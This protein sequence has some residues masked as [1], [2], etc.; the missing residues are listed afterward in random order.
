MLAST[1]QPILR[2]GHNVWRIERARRAAVLI[3]AAAFFSAVREAMLKARRCIF[4]LG[5]DMHSQTPLVGE[6]GEADDGFPQLFGDFLRELVERRPELDIHLLSWDFAFLYAAERELFPRMRFGWQMPER[7]HFRLDNA[8][9][10]GSSQH[11]KLIIVDDL[12]AFSG[13]LDVTIRRW[14]TSE[15]K[16]DNPHRVDPAGAPY[17]PFHDVQMMVDGEAAK[18]LGDLA[19]RRWHR[20]CGETVDAYSLTEEEHPWPAS[21]E[22]DFTDVD[23]GIARTLPAY[24]ND[25]AVSEVEPLFLDSVEAAERS[26]YIENQFLTFKPF[27]QRLARRLRKNP[28]LEALIIAPEKAESWIE[29]RTM[30][31]GRILFRKAL[32]AAQ[33]RVRLMYPEVESGSG[34][35]STMVHSKVMIID[36]RLLRVGSANLNNRSMAAD[37]ECDLVIEAQTEEHRAAI[38]AVRN[39]LLADHCGVTPAAVAEEL[40]RDPSVLSA[41]TRLSG[42]GHRLKPID[43][44]DPDDEELAAQLRRIADPYDPIGFET[45]NGLFES[46]L[47]ARQRSALLKLSIAVALFLALTLVWYVTPLSEYAD[48]DATRKTFAAFAESWYAAPAVVGIFVAAGLLSF[49]VTVL[50]AATAAGFGPALGLLY[51]S[52]GAL[53]SAFVTYAIGSFVGRG[54]LRQV[55][56]PRLDKVRKRI[57][58]RGVIAVAAIRLVPIAPFTLVNL[59]AGASEIRAV[60]FMLGTILGLA[61]GMIVL[62]LLGEQIFRVLAAPTLTSMTFLILAIA[63]WIAV[64]LG[65]QYL[66]TRVWT[67][68]R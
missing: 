6:T 26:V 50:I 9:P 59:A 38:R 24:D 17:A 16:L 32:D 49:P 2:P 22:P 36:D 18:A 12:L 51:A 8:V 56:G 14:D 54:T 55:L 61:P 42:R 29:Y 15:H 25:E 41:G 13:G 21:V 47:T 43:D 34:R 46:W 7:V 64:T 30:R 63:A 10:L 4:V 58:K 28:E 35:V 11:Q 40:E 62:S 33:S 3:D 45:V 57:A 23:V 68:S 65:G 52:I 37:T 31:P 60:D 27:A 5:W 1:H 20:G 53:A 66:L 39:R 67:K 44:G 48:L 19:R